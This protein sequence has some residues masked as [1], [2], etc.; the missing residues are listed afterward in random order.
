MSFDQLSAELQARK[1]QSLYRHRRIL[2]SPQSPEVIVDGQACL[3][4]CSNDY[5]GL[6]NHPNV[7][8]A[9][10]KG[11]DRY[12]VGGGA[13][14][15]VNGHSQAH[16]A[17]EEELAEFTGRPRALL[18]STGY[19]A[20]IGAV[21]AL[22]D[23]RDAVFQDRVN[24]A[25]LL[26]AGLLSGARFQRFLHNDSDNLTLRLQRTEARRK[27]VVCDGVFSMDGDLAELPEICQTAAEHNAWVM[28]DDAHGFGCIGK[29][30]RGTVDHF[31]LGADQVQVLVGTLG[32]AFGTSGA[33]V[34]GSEEL[35]ETLVQHARTYIYTTSMS[36]AIAEAT[37]ASLKLLQQDDW[38]REKLNHL[39]S[40]FQSGCAQLGLPLMDSPTPIQPLMVGES[41]RAMAISAALEAKG[42][43][44]GAIRPPTVPQGEARLRV[45]L[46]ATHT[47]E[48]LD[49][50]LDALSD[51]MIQVKHKEGA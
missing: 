9:L 22:L 17:L 19:M 32:K 41:D 6:A 23:K 1:E 34:A 10:K 21:N 3:A 30:G 27:L 33:F 8:A 5:L 4:F 36:P 40:R 12:G 46:S 37:R 2:Q 25:S 31:G 18:F 50:L 51:V 20:N 26:D 15:L 16:H 49:R 44:I 43:F 24:H 39:I 35:I 28:V 11:A 29:Q 47:D 38:R 45:T 48:Q 13:S 14:H 7:I 42:I